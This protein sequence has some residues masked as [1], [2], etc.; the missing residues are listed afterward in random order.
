[1]TTYDLIVIGLGV[2]GSATVY[3][4]A[5]R[6]L[7]V[8]GLEQFGL[9]HDLG[10]SHGATRIIRRAYFEHPDYIPLVNQAYQGWDMLEAESGCRLLTR[11]G[12]ILYGPP[13]GPI[14][15]GV[16]RAA[17]EHRLPFE[18]FSLAEAARRYPGFHPT[19]EMTA[20]FEA[21]AGFLHV[22]ECIHALVT[23]A[24]AYGAEVRW[25]TPVQHWAISGNQVTVHSA[26]STVRGAALVV[27]AGAW[28]TAI[29]QSL[30]LPLEVRRKV[31]L[32]LQPEDDG[33]DLHTDCP[34]FGFAAPDGFFYGFPRIDDRGV[35]VGDHT[36]GEMVPSPDH[37]DRTLRPDDPRRILEFA[38]RFLPRLTPRINTHSICLYTMTP[39]E[40]FIMDR[41]PDHPNVALAAGFSGH[42][43]KFAPVVGK[44]LV[45]YALHGTTDPPVEFLRLHR[46]GLRRSP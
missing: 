38:R 8:L 36:G 39:D 25:H 20:V 26:D 1:M 44:V 23:Q 10:S 3:D 4:A 12:L 2:M 40:H 29:L 30:N 5:R 42:G 33:F 46:P 34:I 14:L 32:W 31:V 43:F 41:H 18:D 15:S 35:K 22:E 11:C 6:G 16:H 13:D 28:T 27:T 24:Q 45:D 9:A 17:R 37:V 7:R 19:A 21:D